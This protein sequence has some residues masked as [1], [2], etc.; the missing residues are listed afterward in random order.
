MCR[1]LNPYDFCALYQAAKDEAFA[2]PG[3]EY[4]AAF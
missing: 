2:S 4:S 1:R 3:E